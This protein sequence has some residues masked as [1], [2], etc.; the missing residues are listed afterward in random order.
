MTV[1]IRPTGRQVQSRCGEPCGTRTLHH[2][3]I[4][5]EAGK[6]LLA[7]SCAQCSTMT[8]TD[9]PYPTEATHGTSR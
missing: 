6:A 8:L 1:L 7:L 2:V 4:Y 5:E 3:F 9:V